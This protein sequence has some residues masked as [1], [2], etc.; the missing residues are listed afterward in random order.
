MLPIPVADIKDEGGTH[1]LAAAGARWGRS[2]PRRAR[3]SASTS[4]PGQGARLLGAG[5]APAQARQGRDRRRRLHHLPLPRR[6]LRRTDR[7]S[8]SSGTGRTT[9]SSTRRRPRT[10]LPVGPMTHVRRPFSAHRALPNALFIL[11]ARRRRSAATSSC[12]CSTAR[13]SRSRSPSRDH[14]SR[15]PSASCSA[16]WPATTA[17]GSTP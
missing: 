7:R 15:C 8:S 2:R 9:C 6:V 5:L 16:R 11:G 10:L 17:A 14:R 3:S 4:K 12:A 13:R 1:R